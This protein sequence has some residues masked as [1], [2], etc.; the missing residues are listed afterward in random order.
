MRLRA[1]APLD[2]L[3]ERL[4]DCQ[5]QRDALRAQ[6]PETVSECVAKLEQRIKTKCV[7]W[8]GPL[9][10][11][12]HEGRA[13][14]RALLVEPIRFRPIEDGR[15]RGYAFTATLAL[16]QIVSG[17]VDL[18]AVPSRGELS[19]PRV[20][21]SIPTNK[22]G[23]EHAVRIR[24]QRDSNPCFGLERVAARFTENRR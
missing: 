15:R 20:H 19:S 14:L 9:T 21:H 4:T 12:V 22:N 8:L 16:D 7:D 18:G 24:P 11:N 13:V 6:L 17:V 5:R 1:A 2:A 10:R 3:V 23:R